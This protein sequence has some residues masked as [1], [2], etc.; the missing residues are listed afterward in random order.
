MLPVTCYLVDDASL[1][2]RSSCSSHYLTRKFPR[3]LS[4]QIP[5]QK[6]QTDGPMES[7]HAAAYRTWP[8]S[9][10]FRVANCGPRKIFVI[11]VKSGEQGQRGTVYDQDVNYSIHYCQSETDLWLSS[12]PN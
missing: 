7:P 9:S 10:G 8:E 4:G 12:S 3:C 2:A 11:S 1:R 5:V 6:T